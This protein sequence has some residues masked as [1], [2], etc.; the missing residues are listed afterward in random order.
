MS[1]ETG[2][3]QERARRI[4]AGL[5]S[6]RTLIEEVE[7]AYANRDDR[8]LGYKSWDLYVKGEFGDLLVQRRGVAQDRV[9]VQLN[10]AGL[11]QRAIAAVVGTDQKTI[12]NRLREAARKTAAPAEDNSSP[13]SGQDHQSTLTNGHH[14][15]ISS[16]P[17]PSAPPANAGR[18]R[19]EPAPVYIPFTSPDPAPASTPAPEPASAPVIPA[20]PVPPP[21]FTA[22]STR[23]LGYD[24]IETIMHEGLGYPAVMERYAVGQA[25]AQAAVTRA[26]ERQEERQRQSLQPDVVQTA[27]QLTREL[28]SELLNRAAPGLTEALLGLRDAIEG[29]LS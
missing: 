14:P 8:A 5:E 23:K 11:S 27:V 7:A 24:E 1:P 3:A 15:D 18:L 19:P 28:R 22:P 29:V 6:V 17:A 2:Q 20:A 21:V 16:D 10:A 26:G 12:S 9:I 4:R 25:A 13:A